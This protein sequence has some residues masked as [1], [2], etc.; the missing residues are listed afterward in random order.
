MNDKD[1]KSQANYNDQ[2]KDKKND[3]MNEQKQKEQKDKKHDQLKEKQ[4]ENS[5]VKAYNKA[6]GELS[7]SM[8]DTLDIDVFNDSNKALEF[9]KVL[10]KSKQLS[11]KTP[12]EAM[13]LYIKSK[14]LGL[15]FMTASDH[16]HIV[17]GKAGVDIHIIKAKLLR[18][19]G[20][21]WWEK[22]ED[23]TPLY[24]YT[25]GGSFNII[26][27]EDEVESKIPREFA[28]VYDKDSTDKAKANGKRPVWKDNNY[29]PVDWRTSYVFYRKKKLQIT[30]EIITLTEKSSFSWNDAI[31]AKLPLDKNGALAELSNWVKYPGLMCDHRAFTFGARAIASDI[32]MGL[33]DVKELLDSANVIYDIDE[34]GTVIDFEQLEDN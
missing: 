2:D 5:L 29:Q 17:N 32:L 10:V 23:Y 31:T 8:R 16:M 21:I 9:F 1:N 6:G 28:F 18:A 12:E 34:Q 27:K 19:G 3:Q 33:Y 24:Q 15:P 11:G 26:C 14:E 22:T 20:D 30:G 13:V 4:K 25:D 7:F